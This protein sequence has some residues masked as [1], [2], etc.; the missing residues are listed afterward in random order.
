MLLSKRLQSFPSHLIADRRGVS[1]VEFA[2]LAPIAI[3][4]LIAVVAYGLIFS[5][6][7]S[8]QQLVAE[9]TRATVQG[10][11]HDERTAIAREHLTGTIARYP[12]L[13][14]GAAEVFV[15]AHGGL[16]E[17][18]LSYDAEHH[19]AYIFEGLLPLPSKRV[20]YTQVIR[21]GG[22]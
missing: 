13:D 12:M 21:D 11:S 15:S 17:V 16:T 19:P 10:M 9:T 7:I 22:S 8:L 3:V 6:H 4:L 18:R 1:A 5:T 20:T 2:L 14:A